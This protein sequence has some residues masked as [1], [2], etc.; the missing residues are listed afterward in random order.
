[1]KKGVVFELILFFFLVCSFIFTTSIVYASE[2][3]SD[4][5]VGHYSF[6]EDLSD[7][8]GNNYFIFFG[9]NFVP[10]IVVNGLGN[11]G[12]C[13]AENLL[14]NFPDGYSVSFYSNSIRT[15]ASNFD[16]DSNLFPVMEG[17]NNFI[18]VTVGSDLNAQIYLNG[19][20]NLSSPLAWGD[21]LQINFYSNNGQF[22]DELKIYNKVLSSEE[23][24]QL[25]QEAQVN[26][27]HYLNSCNVKG[28]DICAVYESCAG[29]SI[30]ASDSDRCCSVTCTVPVNNLNSCSECG[31]GLFNYCDRQE[32]ETF[33]DV[34]GGGCTFT[35]GLSLLGFETGSCKTTD[36]TECESGNCRQGNVE[37]ISGCSTL[38]Q[39][40]TTYILDENITADGECFKITGKNIALNGNGNTITHEYNS[41]NPFIPIRFCQDLQNIR[42]NPNGNYYLANDIDCSVFDNGDGNGFSMINYFYGVLDGRG[43]SIYNL[44]MRGKFLSMPI[45]ILYGQIKN[46]RL[47]NISSNSYAN[48]DF[49]DSGFFGYDYCTVSGFVQTNVGTL[50]NVFVNGS[51]INHCNYGDV[52][53]LADLNNGI[54]QNS[55]SSV[56][57][58]TPS[59]SDTYVGGISAFNVGTISNSYS[60]SKLFPRMCGSSERT[61]GIAG[62]S[63]GKVENSFS[64]GM[65]LVGEFLSGRI[66]NSYSDVGCNTQGTSCTMTSMQDA[67]KKWDF[68]NI[69][70]IDPA[71]NNGNPYH[72][73]SSRVFLPQPS[74]SA[75]IFVKNGENI[76]VSN[77]SNSINFSRTISVLDTLNTTLLFNETKYYNFKNSSI[78]IKADSG[79]IEYLEPIYSWDNLYLNL[80][81]SVNITLNSINVNTSLEPG[82]NA[83]AK[84]YFNISVPE[85]AVLRYNDVVLN[86]Q[87]FLFEINQYRPFIMSV[88]GFEV[89][90]EPSSASCRDNHEGC[91]CSGELRS[92]FCESFYCPYPGGCYYNCPASYTNYP[93]CTPVYSGTPILC[94]QG[95]SCV[96]NLCV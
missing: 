44:H 93:D 41:E 14:T 65:Y 77:F 28:G 63:N 72:S 82:F 45:Y 36:F 18:T 50:E 78:T 1:M 39:D 53:G 11:N 94:S 20:F 12:V 32:C 61:G 30:S 62:S 27:Q 66:N 49:V 37:H 79:V 19:E 83:R 5:L 26:I 21:A 59:C 89:C 23:I 52:S 81:E 35:P 56:N 60:T 95:K 70:K 84:L 69:W 74:Q 3:A 76:Q 96:D 51:V 92:G 17:F 75:M 91:S 73:F 46:L 58:R 7:S 38:S 57:L 16:V 54:I 4:A 68:T 6:D 9:S 10:S 22:I 2:V 24:T 33:I 87:N 31:K 48:S 43:H 29:S 86:S 55:Y 47:V 8:L 71:F 64:I 88:R 85:N 15:L 13:W 42:D 34:F 80:N 40:G 25:N 67:I 90:D